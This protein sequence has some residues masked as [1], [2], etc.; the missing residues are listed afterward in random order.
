VYISKKLQQNPGRD[1]L[2]SP[3]YTQLWRNL[4]ALLFDAIPT[5]LSGA[6]NLPHINR[7]KSIALGALPSQNICIFW[8]E[9]TLDNHTLDMMAS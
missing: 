6:S 8:R 4:Q 9:D 3:D 2:D 1:F 7:T 5:V